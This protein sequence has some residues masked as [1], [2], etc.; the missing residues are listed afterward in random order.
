MTPYTLQ[1]RKGP[2]QLAILSVVQNRNTLA[3][4]VPRGQD[5]VCL[6]VPVHLLLYSKAVL[7]HENDETV[8]EQDPSC[9]V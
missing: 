3:A 6:F 1:V 7:Q 9:I 2:L 4:R 8:K 5:A